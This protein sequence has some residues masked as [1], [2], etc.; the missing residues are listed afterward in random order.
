VIGRR[1]F[2]L[3]LI[4]APGARGEELGAPGFWQNNRIRQCCSEADA[5]YAD[6]SRVDFAGRYFATVTGGGPRGHDWAPVGREYE[7]PPSAV[8]QY[9]P[10]PEGRALI[11]LN[12]HDL[13]LRCYVQGTGI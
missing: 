5:L 11:F 8:V 6:K 3:G 10:A 1:A 13:S 9:P 12:K 2:I 4:A 7:V